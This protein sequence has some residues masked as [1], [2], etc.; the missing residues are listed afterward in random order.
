MFISAQKCHCIVHCKDCLWFDQCGIS[1]FWS[2]TCFLEFTESKSR[3]EV[4]DQTIL[5]K[6]TGLNFRLHGKKKNL[7]AKTV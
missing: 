7:A 3:S 1:L 2:K 4:T 5:S 6:K